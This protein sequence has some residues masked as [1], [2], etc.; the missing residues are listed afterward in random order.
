MSRWARVSRLP[1]SLAW[2]HL[3][4][5]AV[6]AQEGEV[7]LAARAEAS[8]LLLSQARTI[9][10]DWGAGFG[11]VWREDAGPT[12]G[13]DT[14]LDVLLTP[15][16]PATW[17]Q[18]RAYWRERMGRTRFAGPWAVLQWALQ[19]IPAN[20]DVGRTIDTRTLA[21]RIGASPN[22]A[23]IWRAQLV[24]AGL[25]VEERLTGMAGKLRWPEGF[26]AGELPGIP[27][28]GRPS[29][30]VIEAP[31]ID[32]PPQSAQGPETIPHS[33][34]GT[35]SWAE[36]NKEAREMTETIYRQVALTGV[37]MTISCTHYTITC[38]PPRGGK[39]LAG[40]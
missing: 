28:R 16:H 15:E 31:A 22:A 10:A 39:A 1:W 30:R 14:N 5:A 38:K 4:Q 35:P 20:R 21:S 3:A 40:K 34:S 13:E 29:R 33:P 25:L 6:A 23:R 7:G 8:G 9:E 2:V 26:E 19:A 18:L 32:T 12:W 17:T 24:E 36:I 11:V 27:S 37:T